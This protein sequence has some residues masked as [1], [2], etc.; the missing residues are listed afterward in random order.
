MTL[1]FHLD[2]N[3]TTMT[4]NVVNKCS[5]FLSFFSSM[6]FLILSEPFGIDRIFFVYDSK[7]PYVGDRQTDGQNDGNA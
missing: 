3:V 4:V 2:V 5:V 7:Q 6:I 1:T